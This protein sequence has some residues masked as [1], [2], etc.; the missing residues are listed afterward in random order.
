MLDKDITIGKFKVVKIKLVEEKHAT[1]LNREYIEYEVKRLEIAKSD[2]KKSTK[3]RPILDEI[4]TMSE[5]EMYPSINDIF[6]YLADC[7][8]DT[9]EKLKARYTIPNEKEKAE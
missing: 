2:W 9:I 7:T 5:T 3:K 4:Y 8:I 1:L 6:I